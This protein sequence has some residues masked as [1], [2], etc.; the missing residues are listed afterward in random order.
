M[1]TT[2]EDCHTWLI[3]AILYAINEQPWKN[4]KSSIYQDPNGPDK[5]INRVMESKRLTFYQQLN[6]YNRRINSDTLSL[7]RLQE[8]Y[9]DL[10]T[11]IVHNDSF[12]ELKELVLDY[13]NKKDYF[14]AFMIDII[15]FDNVVNE[16]LN[17]KRLSFYLRNMDKKYFTR[18]SQTY[19]IPLDKVIKAGSYITSMSNYNVKKKIEYNLIRLREVLSKC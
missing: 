13:F 19:E 16:E 1:V 3:E 10:F 17:K 2:P 15:M 5:V 12:I 6:R 4:E 9:N 14:V 11:P 18:F 7:N 8:D